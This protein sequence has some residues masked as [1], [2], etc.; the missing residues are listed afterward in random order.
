MSAFARTPCVPGV[1]GW[2][3]G[4]GRAVTRAK[5]DMSVFIR[6]QGRV[7]FRPMPRR[8]FAGCKGQ[9]IGVVATMR[10]MGTGDR[11]VGGGISAIGFGG[12]CLGLLGLELEV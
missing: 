4:G 10:V 9:G 12:G 3:G 11:R 7:P 2:T 8:S 6:G 1:V 5:K